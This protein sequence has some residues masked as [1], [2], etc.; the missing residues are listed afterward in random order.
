MPYID[1]LVN[2]LTIRFP[3][4]NK[5]IFNLFRLY[6]SDFK[7]LTQER[8]KLLLQIDRSGSLLN[9]GLVWHKIVSDIK[10]NNIED[11]LKAAKFIPVIQYELLIFILFIFIATY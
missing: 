5:Y 11:M 8:E 7:A 4:E 6:L 9:D 1:S 3:E 10:I 2:S